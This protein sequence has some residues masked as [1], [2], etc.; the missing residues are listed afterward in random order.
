MSTASF[1]EITL[2]GR[3]HQPPAADVAALVKETGFPQ[4]TV[5]VELN[6]LALHPDEWGRG[7]APG[8]TVELLRIV[9]GG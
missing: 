9:A 7:L 5:L 1:R 4:S 2:N 6:G 3:P 8:D